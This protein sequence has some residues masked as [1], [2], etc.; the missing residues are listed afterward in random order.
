MKLRFKSIAEAYGPVEIVEQAVR[1]EEAGFD[2]VE[3]S[4]H[5]HPWVGG[6]DARVVDLLD[7]GRFRPSCRTL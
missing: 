6:H 3:V 5:F 7:G 2:S 1:A 4:D